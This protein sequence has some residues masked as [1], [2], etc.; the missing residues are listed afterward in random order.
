MALMLK[1]QR[2][3]ALRDDWYGVYTESDGKRKVINLNVK[4]IGTPPA[5]KL[6]GDAG[7]PEFEES[8]KRAQSKLDGFIEEARRKG[9]ADHLSERLIESKTGRVV[10]HVLIDQLVV[11]P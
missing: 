6:V 5:S 11:H 7:D 2:N 4:I 8:R 3:G 1:R 9:R 10:E